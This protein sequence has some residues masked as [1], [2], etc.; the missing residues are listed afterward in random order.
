MPIFYPPVDFDE[1]PRIEKGG[2]L[3][4]WT[5][6]EALRSLDRAWREIGRAHV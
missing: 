1:P 2:D 6:L 5:V 3:A 4:E